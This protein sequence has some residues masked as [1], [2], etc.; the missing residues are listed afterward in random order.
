[1]L[2]IDGDILAYKVAAACEGA[3]DWGD[4][5]WTLHADALEGKTQVNIWIEDLKENLNA[6]K[7]RVFLT[8]SSN[9]R[10]AFFPEYKANRRGTRKPMILGALRKHLLSMWDAELEEG[11][12]ADDLIG[13]A[14]TNPESNGAIVVSIDKDFKGGPCK[15]YNPDR[16]EEGVRD[17]T[18][19]EADA[20][21]FYQTLVGDSSD[22]YKG[23]P[24]Y[25]P[26]KA[27]ALLLKCSNRRE[28]WEKILQVFD[29]AWLSS[30][31]AL[32]QARVARILRYGDYDFETEKVKLWKPQRKIKK[33]SS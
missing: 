19:D 3:V 30:K 26:K 17:I 10:A 33:Q 16:P 11:L 9:Y 15:L 6:T 7:T 24:A 27:E 20:Y 25:G 13:M 2:L 8:G 14:A 18:K 22:N 12:E 31:H 5:F 1:M 23:C 21:H 28:T 4:D 32:T 29:R